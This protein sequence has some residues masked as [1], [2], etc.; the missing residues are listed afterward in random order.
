MGDRLKP[1]MSKAEFSVLSKYYCGARRIIEFGGGGSTYFA[2]TGT[3][4]S[5]RTVESNTAWI[6]KLRALP[7][8]AEAEAAGRLELLHV[9]IGLTGSWGFPSDRKA[10]DRWPAYSLA[11][12]RWWQRPDVVFV[13][14]R[15]RLACL[16]AAVLNTWPG[17]IIIAHDFWNRDRY[18]PILRHLQYVEGVDTLAVFKR[19]FFVRRRAVLRRFAKAQFDPA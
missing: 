7:E 1:T 13:D 8:I 14:G 9:D 10:R 19:P 2:V 17:A 6:E 15:F 11:P 4:A 12:W 16:L 3:R 18:R 5:I